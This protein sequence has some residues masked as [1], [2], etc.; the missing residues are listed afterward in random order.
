METRWKR[1]SAS[2]I[3]SFLKS[4]CLTA[5]GR[6]GWLCNELTAPGPCMQTDATHWVCMTCRSHASTEAT[7]P[8]HKPMNSGKNFVST[9]ALVEQ[10]LDV[11]GAV[12]IDYLALKE[13][14]NLQVCCFAWIGPSWDSA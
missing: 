6:Q 3:A 9:I 2:S 14:Q 11:G 10:V 8:C 5:C 13:V 4:T 7:L 1:R 12:A